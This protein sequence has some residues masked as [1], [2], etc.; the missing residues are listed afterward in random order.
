[1]PNIP[2]LEKR[3]E[4]NDS[5]WVI[6]ATTILSILLALFIGAF[7]FL[8]FGVEPGSAYLAMVQQ[9]FG[10]LRGIGFTLVRATPKLCCTIAR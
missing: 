1:M 10:S 9:S 4:P 3:L 6:A 8:P 2:F 7:L 5:P